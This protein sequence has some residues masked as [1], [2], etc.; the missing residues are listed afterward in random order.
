MQ[1]QILKFIE[2]LNINIHL[3]L[4]TYHKKMELFHS[5]N[6]VEVSINW[7][8]YIFNSINFKKNLEAKKTNY[9]QTRQM[10]YVSVKKYVSCIELRKSKRER[11]IK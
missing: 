2:D 10:Y 4:H 7:K 6:T 9:L 5:G 11:I 3:N 8:K 1:I